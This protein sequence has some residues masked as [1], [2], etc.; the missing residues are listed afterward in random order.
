MPKRYK[1]KTAIRHVLSACRQREKEG[2]ADRRTDGRTDIET[3][4]QT[5]L[6]IATVVSCRSTS[7]QI[8]SKFTNEDTQHLKFEITVI[9]NAAKSNRQQK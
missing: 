7:H 6:I 3:V 8:T 4:R 9:A 2:E 1:T 5:D